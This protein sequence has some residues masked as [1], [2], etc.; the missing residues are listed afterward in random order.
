MITIN[1][2]ATNENLLLFNTT[3]TSIVVVAK[4]DIM[5]GV[6]VFGINKD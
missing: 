6:R 1:Y 3:A 2:C 4:L 5:L